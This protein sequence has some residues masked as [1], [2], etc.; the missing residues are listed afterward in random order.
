MELIRKEIQPWYDEP[1]TSPPWASYM[2]S[3]NEAARE[4]CAPS[5][6]E[7]R[8]SLAGQFTNFCRTHERPIN[9]ESCAAFL[10][11][12][13]CVASST[14]PRH[15]RMLRSMLQMNRTP[16]DMAIL[17]IQKIAAR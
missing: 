11:A 13:V 15:A 12:I 2:R 3:A 8:M 5:K 7:Q 4:M 16:L 10:A 1:P 6:W 17:G 9:A 14:P